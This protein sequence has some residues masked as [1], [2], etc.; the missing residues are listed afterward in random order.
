MD[1]SEDGR[2]VG[3]ALIGFHAAPSALTAD[4]LLI[5]AGTSRHRK[6]IQPV[7]IAGAPSSAT[8]LATLSM[9]ST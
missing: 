6:A 9:S 8:M 7:Q 1:E 5:S 3:E 2:R 4:S